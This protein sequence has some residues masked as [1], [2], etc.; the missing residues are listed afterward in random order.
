MKT[1]NKRMFEKSYCY[2]TANIVIYRQ[3]ISD[4]AFA[5]MGTGVLHMSDNDLIECIIKMLQQIKGRNEHN[6]LERIF[7][8]VHRL[9]V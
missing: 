3:G 5:K 6:K 4:R 8:Y 7:K 1:E 9:F 2:Y